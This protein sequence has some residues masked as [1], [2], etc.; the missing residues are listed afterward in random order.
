MTAEES[1]SHG[2]LLARHT[3][4]ADFFTMDSFVDAVAVSVTIETWVVMVTVIRKMLLYPDVS[5]VAYIVHEPSLK[6]A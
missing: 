3:G 1:K 6:R 5:T 2:S 4:G